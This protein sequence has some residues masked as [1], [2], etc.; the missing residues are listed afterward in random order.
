M[1]EAEGVLKN[2]ATK[3]IPFQSGGTSID[4]LA[5]KDRL[6]GLLYQRQGK[7][8]DAIEA[9]RAAL[10]EPSAATFSA[11]A[12]D[13]S[14]T[15]GD[16][17]RERTYLYIAAALL[18]A[19]SA[20]KALSYLVAL[21]NI[22]GTGRDPQ[23]CDKN[24]QRPYGELGRAWNPQLCRNPDSLDRRVQELEQ[25]LSK[26]RSSVELRDEL[27]LLHMLQ[28]ALGRRDGDVQQEQ[29]L[30]REAIALDPRDSLNAPGISRLPARRFIDL[31]ILA[32]STGKPE[33]ARRSLRDGVSWYT[34]DP[35]GDT[36]ALEAASLLDELHGV[37]PSQE[38][39]PP[40]YAPSLVWPRW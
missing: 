38:K 16:A 33:E 7:M 30:L 34:G 31:A 25:Q 10:D 24:F 4:A 40:F 13:D 11:Q 15:G 36:W 23:I 29:T 14:S 37:I 35:S 20:D 18:D 26:T 22:H 39:Y 3:H 1:S 32:L 19:K 8:K 12:G 2:I 17:A 5:A 9:Y 28:R 6:R 21:S 27:F